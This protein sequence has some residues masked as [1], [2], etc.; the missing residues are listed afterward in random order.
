MQIKELLEQMVKQDASDLFCRAGSP[1]R[2]RIDGHIVALG[3]DILTTEAVAEAIE[4]ITS[5]EQRKLLKENLDIDFGFYSQVFDKRLR[6]SIFMQ[7]NYPAFVIR[8]VRS[9]IA[10]F[11]ELN[12]PVEALKKLC[13][14]TRGLVLLTGSTGS[15]KSTAIASMIEYIN[16]NT[17]RHILTI[18]EPIEFTFKDKGCIINQRDLG[19]D[20]TSY[21]SALRTFTLQSPDVIYIANIRD[22]ETMAAALTAAE[23]GVLVLSTLHT[24]NA[25]QSIERITNFFPPHQHHQVHMQLA[26]LLKGVISL[27]LVPFK[28]QHGRIPAYEIMLLTPTIG[29]L[30]RENNIQDIPK[31]IE[32]GNIFG[33]QSFAQ[34]LI[35]LVDTGKISE[36]EAFNFADNKDEFSLALRGIRKA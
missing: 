36:E 16:L 3:E 2:L 31:Y 15:G 1:P 21:A 26:S 29:R 23:T 17:K 10:G 8:N 28:N 4:G 18:E 11:E 13:M 5:P 34:S 27:R 12:L 22:T 35:K 33:M 6:V 30:I 25:A 9:N 14:E 24:I 20:V 7:R 19:I 32:E